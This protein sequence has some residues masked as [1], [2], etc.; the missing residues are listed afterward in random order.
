MID[1]EY[2][3][4]SILFT[5]VVTKILSGEEGISIKLLEAMKQK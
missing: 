4:E 1:E 3:F 5:L 2:G